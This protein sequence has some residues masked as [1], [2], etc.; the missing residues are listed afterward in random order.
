MKVES[1]SGESCV[2]AVPPGGELVYLR[3]WMDTSLA[4]ELLVELTRNVAW[5]SRA[6]RMF[7]KKVM[8]PRKIAFQG[9]P[10]ICYAYSGN[11]HHADDWHGAVAGLRDSLVS[12]AGVRF[13][14]ALLNLYRHGQDS[15]GWHADDEPELGPAPIIASVSLGGSRRFVLRR[16]SNPGQKIEIEPEH[17]SLILMRG[18]LQQHWQHQL[19]KTARPVAPRINLTFRKIV[20]PASPVANRIP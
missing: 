11:L 7:G 4:D 16:K 14:C 19:P 15:M 3:N 5:Q 18:D 20:R 1:I 13:N 2:K 6:I 12:P 10:G 8:Q 9:D 17:G